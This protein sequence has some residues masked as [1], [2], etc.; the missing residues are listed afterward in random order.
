MLYCPNPACQALNS[1]TDRF[2]Q[3]CRTPLP[4]RYLW[5]VGSGY[6]AYAPGQRLAGR[7]LCKSDRIFLDTKPGQLPLAST[8]VPSWAEPYLRL[9][10]H[11][12]QVPLAYEWVKGDSGEGILL[13]SEAAL[14]VPLVPA[15]NA[16]PVP[17]DDVKVLPA[18]ADLWPTA[19]PLR[20]LNWLWQIAGLWQAFQDAGVASTLFTTDALRVEG[21]LLRILQLQPDGA[22]VA[23]DRLGQLWAQWATSA[24][25]MIASS[26]STLAQ[27]M[28]Q[29]QIRTG[30]QLVAQLDLLLAQVGRTHSRTIHITTRSDQGPSRQRNEDA[31]FPPANTA[32]TQTVAANSAASGEPAL[33]IVCDGIGGHQGGDVASHLA[34]ET[35]AKQVRSLSLAQLSPVELTLE[36]E[37]AA[38]AANDLISQRNDSEQ[39]Y[40]RQRMGTTLVVGL[41]RGHELYITHVGDSRAY[42]VTRHNCHQIT[43][44]DDVASR[45]VRLGYSFYRDA[46]MQPGAGSLVQALGMGGSALL[47]PTVQRFILDEDS[48]FLLCSDGLSDNDRV[49]AYWD[50]T[51]LPVITGKTPAEKASQHLVNLANAYNG[52]DNVTVGLL[53]VTVAPALAGDASLTEA[54]VPPPTPDF[55][56][57]VVAKGAPATALTP[58]SAHSPNLAQPTKLVPTAQPR[59]LFP[60]LLGVG[61]LASLG[62]ILA[63]FLTRPVLVR[64]PLEASPTPIEPS[65]I[66]PEP[67]TTLLRGSFVQFT[68]TTTATPLVLRRQPGEEATAPAEGIVTPGSILY[69]EQKQTREDGS[70]VKLRVCTTGANPDLSIPEATADPTQPDAVALQVLQP[71]D[72]GWVEEAALLSQSDRPS[73]SLTPFEQQQCLAP[74]PPSVLPSP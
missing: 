28:R 13:L 64:S 33:V 57:L 22:E 39:R 26:L 25:P 47:R 48:V 55:P 56:T 36:L 53:H 15:E 7:F 44:D 31:C 43:Q 45:E 49:E 8:P 10:S 71:A 23:L 30:E 69:V 21:P 18:I 68:P 51:L 37:R 29:G 1:E 62:G 2:C 34:I 46:L 14:Q 3:T 6:D 63:Y 32:T 58:S 17:L 9:S 61:V 42:W 27:Q 35:I 66:A 19:T 20:Q 74:L 40:D 41:V 38:C 5:A 16:A 65:P 72:S 67:L 4:K 59:T 50:I 73:P 54:L 52:H 60:L 11:H 24:Q 12:P 70:W